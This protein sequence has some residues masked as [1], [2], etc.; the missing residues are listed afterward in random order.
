V[1]ALELDLEYLLAGRLPATDPSKISW[2]PHVSD[3]FVKNAFD[4]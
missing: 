3:V 1:H 4:C 2:P